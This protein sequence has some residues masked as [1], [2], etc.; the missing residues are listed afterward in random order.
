MFGA[1]KI[2]GYSGDFAF[3]VTRDIIA[4]RLIFWF[5]GECCFERIKHGRAAGKSFYD[6]G[7]DGR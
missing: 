5:L 6:S 3:F 1:S 4:A 7:G 2:P